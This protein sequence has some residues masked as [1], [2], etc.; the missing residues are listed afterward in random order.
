[1]DER[2][3][4]PPPAVTRPP[5]IAS[6]AA[7]LTPLQEAWSDYVDHAIACADCRHIGRQRCEESDRL[8]GEYQALGA[9]ERGFVNP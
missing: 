5:V 8:Y 9:T 7:R 4:Q 3:D 2:R 1:M 6:G